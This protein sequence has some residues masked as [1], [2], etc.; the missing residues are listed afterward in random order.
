M[1]AQPARPIDI[2]VVSEIMRRRPE[3]R[4]SAFLNSIADGY[5]EFAFVTV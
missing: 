2:G 4:A 1:T 5:P 3:P